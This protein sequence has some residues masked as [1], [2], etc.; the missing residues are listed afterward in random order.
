MN[1][2]SPQLLDAIKKTFNESAQKDAQIKAI[3]KRVANGK[4]TYTDCQLFSK[5]VGILLGNAFKKHFVAS[6][7]PNGQLYYNILESVVTPM[8]GNNHSLVNDIAYRT[9]KALDE[10]EGLGLNSIKPELKKDRLEGI[11]ENV[12]DENISLEESVSRLSRNTVNISESFFD[13]FVK[14]NADFR[15]QCGM[16][17]QIIRI[18]VGNCCTW[19]KDLSG[20]YDYEEV[21]DTE[22]DVFRRHQ[23]CHCQVIYKNNKEKTMTGVHTKRT[24][25]NQQDVTRANIESLD[26]VGEGKK[27]KREKKK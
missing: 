8:I 6:A 5:K 14:E 22:K 21:K 13:D 2:V 7:L 19:C 1:D 27:R 23:D 25:T 16:N 20:T 9:A 24:L 10:K 3:T 11:Y 17:P 18:S 12:L 15:Y 26:G 4:A